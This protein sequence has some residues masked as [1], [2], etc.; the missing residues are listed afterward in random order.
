MYQHLRRQLNEIPRG[1]LNFITNIFTG[2]RPDATT[3]EDMQSRYLQHDPIEE[4]ITGNG[5]S[6]LIYMCTRT[7]DVFISDYERI[8]QTTVSWG[9]EPGTHLPREV[10][11]VHQNILKTPHFETVNVTQFSFPVEILTA[12][13]A[14]VDKLIGQ[15][16]Q[17]LHTLRQMI[18]VPIVILSR[19]VASN[20]GEGSAVALTAK[21]LL[22]SYSACL[23]R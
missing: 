10:V 23:L 12:V 3:E 7:F 4:Q 17:K 5:F 11:L 18:L 6:I 20:P 21:V 2:G 16:A 1:T 8:H 22:E 13:F 15:F 9:G 14:F 19:P